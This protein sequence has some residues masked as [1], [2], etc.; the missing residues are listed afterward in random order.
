[1][2]TQFWVEIS[3][4]ELPEQR[5]SIVSYRGLKGCQMCYCMSRTDESRQTN[6]HIHR[7]TKTDRLLNPDD[8]I[9]FEKAIITAGISVEGGED[10]LC[11]CACVCVNV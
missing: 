8:L 1:M 11:V 3:L 10:N 5:S 4:S 9:C 2:Q 6:E 7:D